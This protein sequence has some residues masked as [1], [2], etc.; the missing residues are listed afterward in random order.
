V[1]ANECYV[2]TA[3]RSCEPSRPLGGHVSETFEIKFRG[4]PGPALRAAFPEFV[5]RPEHGMTV[6]HGEFVDQAALLGAIERINSL[7]LELVGLHLT[8]ADDEAC[9]LCSCVALLA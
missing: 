2:L 9:C 4:E 5:L 8:V 3:R 7:G 6:L 1:A